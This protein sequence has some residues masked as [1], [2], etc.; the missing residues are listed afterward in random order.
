MTAFSDG[1]GFVIDRISTDDKVIAT[2]L[3]DETDASKVYAMIYAGYSIGNSINSHDTTKRS[4]AS[5]WPVVG[6]QRPSDGDG[7]SSLYRRDVVIA[8]LEGN[9]F[10]CEISLYDDTTESERLLAT[11]PCAPGLFGSTDIRQLRGTEGFVVDG[12]LSL[13]PEN[14]ETGCSELESDSL[15][16]P[17][18]DGVY[19]NVHSDEGDTIQE[20]EVPQDDGVVQVVLRG[21]CAFYSKALLMKARSG[22]KAVIVINTEE[23]E[24]FTMAGTDPEN[25][26]FATDQQ[27]LPASVLVTGLDGKAI[28]SIINT[29]ASGGRAVKARISVTKQHTQLE[30]GVKDTGSIVSDRWPIVKG[31]GKSL[32]IFAGGGWGV[33]AIYDDKK[34]RPEWQLQ[35][36]QFEE[37]HFD[38]AF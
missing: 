7:P 28:L 2:F 4:D 29:E 16:Q 12:V 33:K 19:D 9:S 21:D 15:T 32:H 14:D 34:G 26:Q 25:Q 36:V 22:A 37:K 5:V 38:L 13:P 17:E 24:L 23:D 31:D 8:D 35:L 10:L 20:S 30:L 27:E 18:E 1:G 3:F 6:R 11:I